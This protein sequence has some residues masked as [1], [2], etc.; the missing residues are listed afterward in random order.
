MNKQM[1]QAPDSRILLVDD[2]LDMR[3]MLKVA[4][5]IEGYFVLEAANGREAL[6]LQRRQP[7]RVLVTD[8]FMPDADGFEAIDGFRK[9]F[10]ETKIVV[11]SGDA[12]VAKRD[13]LEAARLIG[14]DATLPKPFEPEALI[15]ALRAL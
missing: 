5:E 7:S 1:T 4:L 8:I 10:P 13:Y 6:E 15:R 14:A 3:Q 2:N 11:I 12:R 9:E